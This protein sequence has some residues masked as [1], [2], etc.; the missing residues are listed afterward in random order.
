MK[1]IARS[2]KSKLLLTIALLLPLTVL[3]Q[4]SNPQEEIDMVAVAQF[5][6]G[7]YHPPMLTVEPTEK[8]VEVI[9]K[10]TETGR[11]ERLS[12]NELK[13]TANMIYADLVEAFPQVGQLESCTISF[14]NE[15][16][17]DLDPNTGKILKRSIQLP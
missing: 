11:L 7:K 16:D 14:S 8:G 4:C 6:R 3:V 17:L 13:R 12:E 9:F 2:L 10:A 1:R 15:G 5:V